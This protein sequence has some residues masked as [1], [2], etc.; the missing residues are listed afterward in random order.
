MNLMVQ[1]QPIC[2][3][4]SLFFS[5]FWRKFV[6]PNIESQNDAIVTVKPYVSAIKLYQISERIKNGP[7]N[8]E[9][10]EE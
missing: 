7:S 2:S 6:N 10:D 8:I 9:V 3:I 4:R 1:G 5:D